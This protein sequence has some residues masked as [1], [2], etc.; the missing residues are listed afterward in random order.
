MLKLTPKEQKL[1]ILLACLLVFGFVMKFVLP[2][3]EPLQITSKSE[4]GELTNSGTENLPIEQIKQGDPSAETK[5]TIEIHI[6][7]A[8]A[9]SGVYLLEEG[10][11]VYQAVEKA[12]GPL[13]DAD[14]ERINLAQ[15]LYD[16]QQVIIPRQVTEG[17]S[18]EEG[19]PVLEKLSSREE[20]V[21]INM[22]T[23]SQLEALPGIGSVKAQS[24]IKYRQENG[25]FSSI[26]DLLNVNGIGDKTLEGIR[27]LVS[28][29]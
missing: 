20:K 29:Y 27:E 3:K 21:N 26:E 19:R 25:F 7:G 9:N 8:V 23:Q 28:I 22:A 6:T 16:G 15:P 12:G 2:E 5:K 11:R 17:L 13:E 1:V 14:L 4:A 24:I 10:A 18:G